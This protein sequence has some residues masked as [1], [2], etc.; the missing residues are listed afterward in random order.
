MTAGGVTSHDVI[1][2]ACSSVCSSCNIG[3]AGLETLEGAG[4]RVMTSQDSEN[5][6]ER[7]DKARSIT[8][9]GFESS[10]PDLDWMREDKAACSGSDRQVDT[11]II[12]SE[13]VDVDNTFLCLDSGTISMHEDASEG[14]EIRIINGGSG[15]KSSHKEVIGRGVEE[16]NG[17][18]SDLESR[19]RSVHEGTSEAVV[20]MDNGVIEGMISVSGLGLSSIAEGAGVYRCSECEVENKEG[21]RGSDVCRNSEDEDE[22]EGR[23]GSDS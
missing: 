18:E 14:V 10:L 16:I 6:F 3:M 23:R 5:D 8:D 4:T 17:V 15:T 21:S 2:N 9:A 19:T 20:G 1:P 22:C 7:R 11:G 13:G 12:D